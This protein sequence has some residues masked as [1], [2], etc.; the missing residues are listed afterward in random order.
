MRMTGLTEDNQAE[1]LLFNI[2]S[3]LPGYQRILVGEEGDPAP[4]VAIQQLSHDYDW[5]KRGALS[6]HQR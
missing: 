3:W 1:D 2:F 4:D 6:L 5:H